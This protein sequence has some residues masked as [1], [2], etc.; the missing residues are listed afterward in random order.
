M[1]RVKLDLH[2]DK[3]LREYIKNLIRGQVK[4]E[5]KGIIR[6]EVTSM[7]RDKYGNDGFEKLMKDMVEKALAKDTKLKKLIVDEANRHV[8][9]EVA[10]VFRS[11][12]ED[13]SNI[14]DSNTRKLVI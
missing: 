13:Y 1:F 9:E 2:E 5:I 12:R 11:Y 7:T 6:D 8:K 3:P 10:R 4:S 14:G